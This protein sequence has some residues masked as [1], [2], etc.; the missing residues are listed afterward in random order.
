MKFPTILFRAGLLA[1]LLL[2][3]PGV[4]AEAL[5]SDAIRRMVI[6]EARRNG[7]VP[8]SIALGV[9]KVESGF[10]ANVESHKGARGVMQIMPATAAGEFGRSA[11]ELWDPRT[12]IR[13][14]VAYLERLYRQYGNRW[15][16]A[17]SHYNGGTMRGGRGSAARPH[18]YTRRY[19]ADVLAW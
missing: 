17:L 7:T 13:L 5:D 6:E 4:Q 16:A 9:A 1:L 10:R 15:D 12:N 11:D 14:G 18:G 19:V 2:Q 8:P 3:G